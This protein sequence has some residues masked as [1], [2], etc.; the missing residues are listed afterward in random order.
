MLAV[1]AAP[2]PLILGKPD[3]LPTLKA[4]TEGKFRD[5]AAPLIL[6][7]HPLGTTSFNLDTSPQALAMET[8]F[9][10]LEGLPLPE[11]FLRLQVG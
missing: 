3:F 1:Q 11:Q 5:N 9:T 10:A 2:R 6:L 4:P 7:N 8:A